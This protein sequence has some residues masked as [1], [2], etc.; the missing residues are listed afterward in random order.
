MNW[1][2]PSLNSAVSI[3]ANRDVSKSENR[4][5]NN[6]DPNEPSHQDLLFTQESGLV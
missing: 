3:F 5:A 4:M 2:F 1:T 6:V